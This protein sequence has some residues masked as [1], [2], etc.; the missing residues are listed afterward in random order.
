VTGSTPATAGASDEKSRRTSGR[1]EKKEERHHGALLKKRGR[2]PDFPILVSE[3]AAGIAKVRGKRK[4]KKPPHLV[5]GK[6]EG[7][8]G[9]GS[10]HYS[11]IVL[12]KG[13]RAMPGQEEERKEKHLPGFQLGKEGRDRGRRLALHLSYAPP[14]AKKKGI[15]A[16]IP[17][18]G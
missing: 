8:G 17:I 6:K 16:A 9:G 18:L 14:A 5:S 1:K 4:R 3:G 7:G 11:F 15:G 2:L 13:N 12:R 10:D